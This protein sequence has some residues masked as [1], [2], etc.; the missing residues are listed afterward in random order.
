M[1][2][3]TLDKAVGRLRKFLRDIDELNKLLEGKESSDSQLRMAVE[4]A[5]D[6]W[7][8]TPPLIA[9]VTLESHPSPR[10][11]LRGAAI[12]VLMSAGIFYSRNRLN[13]SDGGITVAVYDKAQDYQSWA[14][15]F[16]ADYERKKIEVKKAIN[17]SQGWGG[18]QSEYREINTWW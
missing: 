18:L 9:K 15:Q 3:T 12:E 11:L 14:N 2:E 17:I 10:L 6:D 13:Y 5:L 8:N 1:A 16:V 4:D 7:N